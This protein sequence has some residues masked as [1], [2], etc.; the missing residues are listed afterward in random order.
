MTAFDASNFSELVAAVQSTSA[1]E[2]VAGIQRQEGG[3]DRV[4]DQVFAGMA[5]AFNPARA[6][7]ARATV[8]YDIASPEGTKHYRMRIADG[9]CQ[10]DRGPAEQPKATLRVG[11]ADFLR[12][13]AGTLNPMQA[14][15]TGKLK[16][17]GDLF[18]LQSMQAW[19]DRPRT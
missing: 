10:V 14:L 2:L 3:I 19:F 15:M 1:Q 4:L 11:L 9:R 5:G 12:V 8:Q 7:A 17:A 13:V 6:G 18:F 16:V